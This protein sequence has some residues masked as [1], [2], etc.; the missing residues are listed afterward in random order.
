M[1]CCEGRDAPTCAPTQAGC[2]DVTHTLVKEVRAD[3]SPLS[4]PASGAA[5]VGS[6]QP[7]VQA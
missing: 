5:D 4:Q 3:K 6:Y 2:K 1:L 7:S